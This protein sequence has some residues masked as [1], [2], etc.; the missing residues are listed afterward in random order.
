MHLL[1]IED[2]P[3]VSSYLL[4]GLREEGFAVDH[5]VDGR[6]GLYVA[7]SD[8]Y[9]CIIVDRMLPG[10]DG[11]AVIRSLRASGK[12]MPVIILSALGEV[13]DRVDGLE[14]GADDYLPKPFAFSEL[15][16]RVNALRRRV[17]GDQAHETELRVGDLQLDLLSHTAKRAGRVIELQ[18]REYRMLEYL[19]RHAGQVVTRTM[20]L[21]NVWDYN[22]DPQTNVI[23][24]LVSRLRKKI[25]S[26]F[27]EAL[28]KTVRGA[29][30]M[31]HEAD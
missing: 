15:V 11:L 4:K 29:G 27:P 5:V 19:M 25:D 21:E 30:Y 8:E 20:L 13:D 1:L 7:M 6:D 26:D 17:S 23:D 12:T 22:F 9:D 14:A 24:V 10:L 28:L 2:D 3:E 31:I 18:P 16:A